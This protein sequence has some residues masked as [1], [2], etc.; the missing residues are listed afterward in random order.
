M[1][2]ITRLSKQDHTI[3]A[4]CVSGLSKRNIPSESRTWHMLAAH[5][6]LSTLICRL[7]GRARYRARRA[8]GVH[9]AGLVMFPAVLVLMFLQTLALAACNV[10]KSAVRLGD[11][12]ST[13]E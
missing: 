3:G 4:T 1:S 11:A 6:P 10:S 9:E 13:V 7:C 8:R 2:I 12:Y 5:A